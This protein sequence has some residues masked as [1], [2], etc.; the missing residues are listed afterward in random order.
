MDQQLGV[1]RRP[2]MPNPLSLVPMHV[3]S[4]TDDSAAPGATPQRVNPPTSRKIKRSTR[5]TVTDLT[6]KPYKKSGK[7]RLKPWRVRSFASGKGKCRFFTTRDQAEAFAKEQRA[8]LNHGLDPEDFRQSIMLAKGT[9]FKVSQLVMMAIDAI[10]ANGTVAVDPNT[11]F[12]Q[13]AAMVI[14]RA[15]RRGRR[16]FTLSHYRA[17]FG[18][19]IKDF[20]DKPVALIDRTF[21]QSYVD[22]LKGADGSGPAAEATKRIVVTNIRMALAI[23]G[24]IQPLRNIETRS[25]EPCAIRFFTNEQ[26]RTLLAGTPDRYKG[27]LA[28]MLFGCVRPHTMERLTPANVNVEERKIGTTARQNKDKLAHLVSAHLRLPS[29]EISPGSPEIL[30]LWVERYPFEAVS[31][32][33]LQLILKTLLGGFWLHDGLR[34]TGATNY[35]ALWG[36]AATAE[37]LTHKGTSLVKRHYAGAT[38]KKDAAEFMGL[39]PDA[40]PSVPVALPSAPRRVRW[41]DDGELSR[42]VLAYR[43]NEVARQIGCSVAALTAHCSKRGIKGAGRGHWTPSAESQQPAA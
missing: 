23:C 43:R 1:M 41:P 13:A 2:R 42:M 11:T 39:T 38:W 12:A 16:P 19:L 4:K 36:V 15:V 6:G 34:H 9:G 3:Q 29:G 40:V 24:V 21:V 5:V 27:A 14:A 35:C 10:K 18:R 7:P 20:G 33:K 28:L 37:L 30:W 25:G 22:A 32:I 17:A 8:L 31:W 26:I